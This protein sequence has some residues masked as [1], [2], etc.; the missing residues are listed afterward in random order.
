M[1]TGITAV[2]V[3]IAVLLVLFALGLPIV[4]AFLLAN[5]VGVMILMGPAGFGMFANSLF[6]T[7][8]T[9]ELATIPLFLLVGELLFRGRAIDVLF[10]SVDTL[11]SKMRGRQYIL[12]MLLSVIFAALSGAAMGVA[13]MLGRSVL[14][15]MQERGY[16]PRLSAGSILAGA[17]LAPII[18]PSVLAIIIGTLAGVSISGLLIAGIIPG[19][20]LASLFLLYVFVRV[21][22][23]PA[24]A[25]ADAD[26]GG[27]Q[28]SA[29]DKAWALV[30]MTPFSLIIIFIMG[31]ILLGITTPSESAAT[32]VIGALLAAAL[33]RRLSLRMIW[34]SLRSSMAVATMILVIMASSKMFGQFLAFTG[35]TTALTEMVSQLNWHPAAMFFILMFFPFIA[36]MFIDQIALMLIVIPIYKPLIATLGFDP[37]WFWLIFLIN[38]TIGGIT[39]PFGYT[40]F[41]LKGSAPQLK[42][43]DV[44][45][46]AWPFVWMFLLGIFVLW[47]FPMLVTYLPSKV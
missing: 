18:P 25:P 44:F 12:T 36:C 15:G 1:L 29:S 8:T 39:P 23:N 47:M 5:L 7:A 26:D 13:A 41:A 16:D 17:S 22:R 4:V 46:A 31:F 9:V 33:Y 19:L 38:I 37:I 21:A 40:L 32:G 2:V 43:G 45:S 3:A 11:V 30:R 34:E 10:E 14:P 27:R 28:A 20:I 24:L 6:D 35:G 42:L